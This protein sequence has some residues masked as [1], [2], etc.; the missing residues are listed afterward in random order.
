ML[1][2]Y[3]DKDEAILDLVN[4]YKEKHKRQNAERRKKVQKSLEKGRDV[5][6]KFALDDNEIENIFDLLE[7]EHP[8]L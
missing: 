4:N 1:Q 6:T 3:I 8:E 5:K 7:Q 2:N